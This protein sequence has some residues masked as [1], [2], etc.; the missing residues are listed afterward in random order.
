MLN[1]LD[2]TK[3]L[4]TQ[5][6]QKNL[7]VTFPNKNLTLTNVNIVYESVEL[8]ESIETQDQLEFKGCNSSSFKFS[9]AEIFMDLRNEYLEV[10]IQAETSEVIPLF[11]GYV[12]SQTNR[13]CEDIVTEFEC[14]DILYSIRNRDVTSWYNGLTFPIT[15]KNFR[16][17]FFTLLGI[18]QVV[19]THS[20][21]DTGDLIN[22]S[23]TL[24]KIDSAK[25]PKV[26]NAGTVMECICQC[27]A[28]YGQYGRDKKFHYRQLREIIKG[29]Y[30]SYETFPSD[31][32]YPSGENADAIY[33]LAHYSKISYEPY[34]VKTIDGVSIKAL[35]GTSTSYGNTTNVFNIADNM[36]ASSLSDKSTACQNILGEVNKVWY[37]PLKLDA[38]GCP[39]IE[40]GDILLTRTKKNIVR[41]YVLQR[42]LKGIQAFFDTFDTDGIEYREKYVESEA[43]GVST[44]R[45]GVKDAKDGVVRCNQLIADEVS[46]RVGAFNS[47][48]ADIAELG[49]VTAQSI[50][51]V[52]AK[53]ENLNAS[54][55]TSGT[56]SLAYLQGYNASLNLLTL[57]S[58][59]VTNDIKTKYITVESSGEMQYQGS[60]IRKDT[61]TI[62]GT[63]IKFLGW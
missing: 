26:L 27:N 55:I 59:T 47:L 9:C 33:N 43:T 11:S 22:D 46:A 38:I 39:W 28:R 12:V 6:S 13:T 61:V 56:M 36:L 4:Y 25:L 21:D 44:N 20:E 49:R 37:I 58:L 1:V 45:D 62:Q 54:K 52:D 18:D 53:F 3:Q 50:Q 24:T 63:T 16:D 32:T 19:D 60:S 34:M 15:M 35:D 42:T 51:A 57:S 8:K 40:C 29:L 17:S 2:S 14:Q 31:T 30:P 5:S 41:T 10:T 23:L 48:S 7:V